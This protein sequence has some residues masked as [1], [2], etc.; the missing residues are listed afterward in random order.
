M[1]TRPRAAWSAATTPSGVSGT[2][3]SPHP[4]FKRLTDQSSGH[5]RTRACRRPSEDILGIVPLVVL[6]GAGSG[7]RRSLGTAVFVPR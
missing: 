2:A 4:R 3:P 1:S 6:S 5:H 7:S